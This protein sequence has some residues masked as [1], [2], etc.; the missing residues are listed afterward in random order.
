MQ[1]I[2]YYWTISL[3]LLLQTCLV[4]RTVE[5][6]QEQLLGPSPGLL[7]QKSCPTSPCAQSRDN[8]AGQPMPIGT[9]IKTSKTANS[10]NIPNATCTFSLVTN[11]YTGKFKQITFFCSLKLFLHLL[12]LTCV[13]NLPSKP[14]F[15]FVM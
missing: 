4:V 13:R 1:D 14:L 3:L 10:T 7:Y 9:K 6:L 15:H 5:Q 8:L 11:N 2:N 12:K